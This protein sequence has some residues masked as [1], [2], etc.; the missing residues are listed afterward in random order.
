MDPAALTRFC[1]ELVASA[2]VRSSVLPPSLELKAYEFAVREALQLLYDEV[3]KFDCRGIIGHR[4]TLHV[5]ATLTTRAAPTATVQRGN[6]AAFA[7]KLLGNELLHTSLKWMPQALKVEFIEGVVVLLLTA[8]TVVLESLECSV[9]GHR[10]FAA[11][12]SSGGFM[13][14]DTDS[15]AAAISPI[16]G[17]CVRGF[18][19]DLLAKRPPASPWPGLEHVE[20]SLACAAAVVALAVV[21]DTLAS[22]RVRL[23]GADVTARLV[24][25]PAPPAAAAP[26]AR[27]REV[28]RGAYLRALEVARRA[29]LRD[30]AVV[31]AALK[32]HR[33]PFLPVPSLFFASRPAA[34]AQPMQCGPVLPPRPR[35]PQPA[36]DTPPKDPTTHV[37]R[38]PTALLSG[39]AAAAAR[40]RRSAG[41]RVSALVRTCKAGYSRGQRAGKEEKDGDN[42]A[43]IVSDG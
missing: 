9:L 37:K 3:K 23:V 22:F 35:P 41:K 21:D 36:V 20:K 8:L 29:L 38:A 11:V 19:D 42:G 30:V 26:V 31:D 17:A 39:A 43:D 28:S 7:K 5:N 16:D 18:V 27:C 14:R 24:P 2:G 6:V 25:A 4:L 32:A 40:M 10:V 15:C 1:E 13:P 33:R 34:H 12:T